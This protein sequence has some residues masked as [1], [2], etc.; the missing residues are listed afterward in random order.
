MAQAMGLFDL[1]SGNKIENDN[2]KFYN[3]PIENFDIEYPKEYGSFSL[4]YGLTLIPIQTPADKKN[5]LFV[6]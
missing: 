1:G 2:P 6:P 3:P 4:P 5:T